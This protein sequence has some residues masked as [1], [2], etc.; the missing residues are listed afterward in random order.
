[1][2]TTCF[3]IYCKKHPAHESRKNL[4]CLTGYSL[5]SWTIHKDEYKESMAEVNCLQ[6]ESDFFDEFNIEPED[7][8]WDYT[9]YSDGMSYTG[10]DGGSYIIHATCG[11]EE[12]EE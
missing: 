12:H 6:P 9:A 8:E 2:K 7:F 10:V 5:D 11:N 3:C 4:E 1:M